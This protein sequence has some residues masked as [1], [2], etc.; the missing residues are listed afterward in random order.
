V[1]TGTIRRNIESFLELIIVTTPEMKP[2][3]TEFTKY[4][5]V[6]NIFTLS[7]MNLKIK[8]IQVHQIY[9]S[10][11]YDPLKQF[12]GDIAV[13]HLKEPI[14]YST[15]TIPV[16]LPTDVTQNL[17]SIKTGSFGNVN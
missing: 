2:Q 3:M 4:V 12:Q 14:E 7:V 9:V 15:S 11:Y 6:K 8:L 13:L 17:Y 16:C 1:V 10:E 5:I